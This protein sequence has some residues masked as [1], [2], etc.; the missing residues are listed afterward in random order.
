MVS[1]RATGL[2][3]RGRVWGDGAIGNSPKLLAL[4]K[5]GS[6]LGRAAN[7]AEFDSF[8]WHPSKCLSN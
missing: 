3:S 5:D 2:L 8:E 6:T 1:S 4:P 7:I